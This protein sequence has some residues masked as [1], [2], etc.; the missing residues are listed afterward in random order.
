MHT[1][2]NSTNDYVTG[3]NCR[4]KDLMLLTG[5]ESCRQLGFKIKDILF[6]GI[7]HKM[8]KLGRHI[9]HCRQRTRD[10]QCKMA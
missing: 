3:L 8:T 2:K 6:P 10:R 4:R 9:I 1:K 7:E 5:K